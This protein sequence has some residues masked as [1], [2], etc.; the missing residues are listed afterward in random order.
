M[1]IVQVRKIHVNV[2]IKSSQSD[3]IVWFLSKLARVAGDGHATALDLRLGAKK[4]VL[5]RRRRGREGGTAGRSWCF[6]PKLLPS[7]AAAALAAASVGGTTK[8][9]RRKAEAKVS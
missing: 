1:Q 4:F 5:E 9:E 2:S 7:A 6:S 3:S 8:R